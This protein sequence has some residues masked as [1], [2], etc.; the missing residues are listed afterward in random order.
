MRGIKIAGIFFVAIL[1]IVYVFAVPSGPETLNQVT[2]SRYSTSDAKNLSAQAGNVSEVNFNATSITQTWQGY[3]GNI[4]GQVVLGN[5]NNQ[6][7]YNWNLASPKGEIYATSVASVPA[8]TNIRCTNDTEITTEDTT[9]GANESRD[10]DSVNNTFA[11]K[12]H[13]PFYVGTVS[14]PQ[15]DCYSVHLNNDTGAQSTYFSQVLLSDDASNPVIYTAL[16]E[17]N[18]I[19]F[20]GATHDFQMIV[21][22]NGHGNSASTLYYFYVELE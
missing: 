7:L 22:E 11:T 6:T 13:D 17:D 10:A 4:T 16:I 18:V 21:G 1:A 3:F 9:L 5:G 15:N 14:I 12:A 20:D 8:W 19:G 2:T